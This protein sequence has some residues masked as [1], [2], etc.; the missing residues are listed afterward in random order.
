MTRTDPKLREEE[1]RWLEAIRAIVFRELAGVSA[2]VWLFGSRAR[3][4]AR[5]TSDIDIAVDGPIPI[6]LLSHVREALEESNVPV[7]VDV[8][9]LRDAD[10]GFRARVLEEGVLWSS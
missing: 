10:A 8:I 5:R 9:D 7:R 3:G 1:A 2:R 4:T 6:G